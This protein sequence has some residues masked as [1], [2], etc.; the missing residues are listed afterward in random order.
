MRISMLA[1]LIAGIFIAFGCLQTVEAANFTIGNSECY[2]VTVAGPA[3]VNLGN[4]VTLTV[5]TKKVGT[6]SNIKQFLVAVIDPFT[7]NSIYKPT[8]KSAGGSVVIGPISDTRAESK[9]VAAGIAALDST[10]QVVG[11]GWWAFTVE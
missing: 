9:L 3:S 7:G 4:S 5:T 6:C 2:D 8:Y 1:I 10:K 11:V